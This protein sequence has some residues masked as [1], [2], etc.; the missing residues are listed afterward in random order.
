MFYIDNI[1]TVTRY[2]TAKFLKKD[3]DNLD[4]LDSFMLINIPLLPEQGTYIVT[5]EAL[6]PDLLSYNLYKNTQ[7]WWILMLY[8]EFL[9]IDELQTGVT[10]RYP[11]QA[12]LESLYEQASIAKKVV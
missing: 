8:N 10:V 3:N 6:R 12:S 7:Y 5:N 9:S 11:S 1:D 4:P 2:D